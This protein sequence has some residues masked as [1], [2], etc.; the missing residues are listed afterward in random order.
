MMDWKRHTGSML[1]AQVFAAGGLWLMITDAA[2]LHL[3]DENYN[4]ANEHLTSL[5]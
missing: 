4:P 5:V 2:N 1:R 3:P